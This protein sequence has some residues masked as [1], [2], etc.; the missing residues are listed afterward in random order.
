MIIVQQ[1]AGQLE[2]VVRD[3][4]FTIKQRHTST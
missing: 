2:Y 1:P 4:D 3:Y